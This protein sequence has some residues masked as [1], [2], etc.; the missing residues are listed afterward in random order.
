MR[1]ATDTTMSWNY[2][3][4]AKDGELAIFEVFYREDGTV[5]G[6]TET[7]VFPRAATIDELR[8]E[9]QRYAEALE[10]GIL[11]YE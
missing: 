4:M 8:E 1:S 5:Q 2:R 6:Y 11:R 7:P 9:L 3:V 10:R